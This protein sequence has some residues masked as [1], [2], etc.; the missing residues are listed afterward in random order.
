VTCVNFA[1]APHGFE[2]FHDTLETRE[3]MRQMFRFARFHLAGTAA[4]GVNV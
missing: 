3:V 1:A 2:V 4:D